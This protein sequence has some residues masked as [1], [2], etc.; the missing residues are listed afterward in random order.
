MV[1]LQGVLQG[2][3][4]AQAR[5]QGHSPR[6][7]LPVTA[8]VLRSLKAAWEQQGPSFDRTMLWAVA[9]T[10][11][12]GFLRSGEATVP[13]QSAFDPSVH[14][15]VAD[16][17]VDCQ[18]NPRVVSVRIK[19]SKTDPFRRGVSIFL[20][21]TDSDLCPVAAL[22][23]YLAKRGL[24]PGPL[25]RFDDGRPLTRLALVSEVRAA[26]TVAG[27]DPAP[28][29]GHSFRIGAATSA[30]AAGI[31]DAVIKTLGRWRSDAYQTYVR[32]PREAITARLAHQ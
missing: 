17:A 32:L 4:R 23:S 30:A 6:L 13:S 1:V 11:F 15:S 31:E 12:F 2:I 10:C 24:A 29:S 21:K 26:L 25:F 19:M 5:D 22:L 20:G 27:I 28:Y 9:C 18:H 8:G 16:I 14:L 3:K 7:R